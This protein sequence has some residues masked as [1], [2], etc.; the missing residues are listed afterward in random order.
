[1][2]TADWKELGVPEID[3]EHRALAR[4]VRELEAAVAGGGQSSTSA[5]L[6]QLDSYSRF[7]FATEENAMRAAAFPGIDA[8]IVQHRKFSAKIALFRYERSRRDPGPEVLRFVRRWF[9]TH[10]MGA[11]EQFAAFLRE[12]VRQ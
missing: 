6:E 7:H 10:T 5:L 12:R 4:I 8:H 3:R 9:R 2:K 1:V 11:D